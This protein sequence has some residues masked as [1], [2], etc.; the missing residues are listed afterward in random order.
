M[1]A[2]EI[3]IFLV[4]TSLLLSAVF[5]FTSCK[6]HKNIS[7]ENRTSKEVDNISESI[8]TQIETRRA[9]AHLKKEIS[10]NIKEYIRTTDFDSTGN[11]RSVS[12]TWREI[13]RADMAV[14]NDSS[15]AISVINKID[16]IINIETAHEVKNEKQDI[17]TDQRPVQGSEWMWVILGIGVI[18]AVLVIFLLEK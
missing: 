8:Y 17:K 5:S 10:E 2:Y 12:E 7:T 1:K 15:G 3:N 14:R 6:S 11:I 9:G 4:T 16:S 18:A 13:G